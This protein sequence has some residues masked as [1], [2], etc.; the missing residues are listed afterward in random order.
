MVMP[1][2]VH[3]LIEIAKND[4]HN[5][6]ETQNFASLLQKP[7]TSQPSSYKNKFGPQSRNLSSIIRGFKIGVTKNASYIQPDFKWQS[8]FHDHIVRNENSFYRIK[9]Y[10]INNTINWVSD[11]FNRSHPNCVC[12]CPE[13][14]TPRTPNPQIT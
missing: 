11:V 14:Q 2:H 6:V 13:E 9:N 1:N 7:K 5:T 8:R 12:S 4:S 10:I 3:G